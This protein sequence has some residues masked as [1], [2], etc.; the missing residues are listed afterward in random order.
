[1]GAITSLMQNPSHVAYVYLALWAL[2]A[3]AH[4]MPAP[5]ERSGRGYRWSYNLL[6]FL[7]ANLA[8]LQ[9]PG[10]KKPVPPQ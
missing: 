8:K 10:L 1:M 9:T 4:T 7:L 2:A 6:Q 3:L 5:D